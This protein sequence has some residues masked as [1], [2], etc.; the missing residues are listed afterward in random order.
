MGFLIYMMLIRTDDTLQSDSSDWITI[1][2]THWKY[3]NSSINEKDQITPKKCDDFIVCTS[4]SDD[5][6]L[7]FFEIPEII[8]TIR[9]A[10]IIGIHTTSNSHEIPQFL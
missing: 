5:F 4:S 2:L 6:L 7:H 10:I 8:D 3:W 1:I 9:I